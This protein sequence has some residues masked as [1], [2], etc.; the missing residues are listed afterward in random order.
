MNEDDFLT[1][2]RED[3]RPE[4]AEQL[5]RRIDKPMTTTNLNLP[6]VRRLALAG[7]LS[8]LL[9]L[10]LLALSPAARAFAGDL[11]R[12]IGAFTVAPFEAMPAATVAPTAE[13]PA[14]SDAASAATGAE[15]SA[16]AGFA[17]RQPS[18][19]PDGYQP[20][21]DWAIVPQGQ[22]VN[23]VRQ[24]LAGQGEHFLI[25][26]QY[27]YGSGDSYEQTYGDN[28]S[29]S[30][31]QVRGQQALA[32]SGRL[33]DHPHDGETG[34]VPTN[35]LMWEEGGINYT[36]FADDLTIDDLLRIAETLSQ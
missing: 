2:F 21:G 18:W 14:A 35:W 28:E 5:Y 29:V 31:V 25:L 16:L 26:N 30:D 10:A 17:V 27:R 4:F 33:M 8:T 15:A 34:L 13:P 36:L 19:L 20:D 7:G 1:Q 32:I 24:Y 9:L 22:G 11:V 3:P 6:F 23:A 12:Q